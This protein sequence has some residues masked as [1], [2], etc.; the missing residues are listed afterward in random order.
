MAEK[1]K[2]QVLIDSDDSENEPEEEDEEPSVKNKRA[3]KPT[4]KKS[5]SG[6]MFTHKLYLNI[7]CHV[8]PDKENVE[9]EAKK[10]AALRKQVAKLS[11]KLKESDEPAHSKG[12]VTYYCMFF[13]LLSIND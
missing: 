13:F 10:L 4:L 12:K 3:K 2:R 7:D 9:L 6:E 11:R 5:I 8:E 1:R